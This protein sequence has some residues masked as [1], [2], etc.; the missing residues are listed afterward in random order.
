MFLARLRVISFDLFSDPVLG[1]EILRINI[2]GGRLIRIADA[3]LFQIRFQRVAADHHD[4]L[5]DK[6]LQQILGQEHPVLLRNHARRN[7]PFAFQHF[8]K[9]FHFHGVQQGKGVLCHSGEGLAGKNIRSGIRQLFPGNFTVTYL[10]QQIIHQFRPV[11]DSAGFRGQPALRR[12]HHT[13]NL[14]LHTVLQLAG[15]VIRVPGV[16]RPQRSRFGKDICVQQHPEAH[17]QEFVIGKLQLFRFNR[18]AAH[19][20]FKLFLQFTLVP[21][22]DGIQGV[23][24]QLIPAVQHDDHLVHRLRQAAGQHGV[25]GLQ[26]FI[27]VQ[28]R[29]E[30]VH[31]A[32][33]SIHHGFLD[34]GSRSHH[35]HHVRHSGGLHHRGRVNL[36]RLLQIHAVQQQR[37]IV[38]ISDTGNIPVNFIG[39]IL[40]PGFEAG[41]IVFCH[42]A[43]PGAHQLGH[44][45]AGIYLAVRPFLSLQVN[46]H[47]PGHGIRHVHGTLVNLHRIGG[48]RIPLYPLDI[49]VHAV[50]QTQDQRNAD[51]ADGSGKSRQNSPALFGHQV[52]QAQVQRGQEAHGGFPFRRVFRGRFLRPGMLRFSGVV[53]DNF[54]VQ[55]AD[56]PG[57]ILIRQFRVMGHH[58]HQPVLRH[59]T[60]DLHDLDAGLAV[61][62]AGRFIRQQDL[63]VVYQ[64]AGNGDALHLAAAEL[65]RLF[66][67]LVSQAYF[68]QRFR[69]PAAALLP[70][71]AG[72]GQ[73]QFH[74]GKHRLVRN[75]VIALEYKTHRMIPVGIPVPFRK[76]FCGFSPDHQIAGGV[77]VQAADNIQQRCFSAAGR[78]QDRGKFTVA[79]LQVHTPERLHPGVARRIILHNVL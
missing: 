32:G 39:R 16:I 15:Y 45:A 67:Q 7:Q 57:G 43:H 55:Q 33:R 13:H 36:Q 78:P 53:T 73:G 40:Q 75:Q 37:R 5:A 31:P 14:Q 24:A 11:A 44:A 46:I 9:V 60:Q 51:D 8:H 54:T 47:Q 74:V 22:A 21:Q 79:E 56:Y 76:L 42:A 66:L 6:L 58:D 41:Q 63:R 12:F 59:L 62:R 70:A 35:V 1:F 49:T 10:L 61:Q 68:L 77:P 65:I 71:D 69:C 34:T 17:L 50:G 23:I 18:H 25:L 3:H 29:R 48:Q 19:Q 72:K 20:L 52:V 30:H 4:A 27:I 64:R 2:D 28:Q 38:L 26:Q